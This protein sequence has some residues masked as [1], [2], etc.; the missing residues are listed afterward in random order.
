M[1]HAKHKGMGGHSRKPRD[2]TWETWRRNGNAK[3]PT[4]HL[5]PTKPPPPP[6]GTCCCRAALPC[7][8]PHDG[9]AGEGHKRSTG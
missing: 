9:S 5:W 4:P 2:L 8:L 1:G 3:F 6:L 7:L